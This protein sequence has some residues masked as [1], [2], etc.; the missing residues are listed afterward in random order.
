MLTNTYCRDN[1]FNIKSS[2]LANITNKS[3]GKSS[4]LLLNPSNIV[5]SI[6][7]TLYITRL[8]TAKLIS[9]LTKCSILC[10]HWRLAV[11]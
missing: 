8:P 10:R 3:L 4:P 9:K 6:I 2:N 5:A 11:A 7:I 1:K